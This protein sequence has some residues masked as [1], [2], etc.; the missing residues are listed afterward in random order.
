M[1]S[2]ASELEVAAILGEDGIIGEQ[3]DD[4]RPRQSQLGMAELINWAIA[5]AESKIIEASTGIG[6]SFAYLV[7]AYL[8]DKK[9]IISTGTKN[10]QD[11]LY[12][13]DIPLIRKTVISSKKNRLTERS[14]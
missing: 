14:Q 11:Q 3:I 13:K 10:L 7:P 1:P 2:L 6:K 12:Y 9:V 4:F 8:S 5:N